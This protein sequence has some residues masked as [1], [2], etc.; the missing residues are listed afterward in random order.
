MTAAVKRIKEKVMK[1]P[2]LTL[3][4]GKGNL[5]IETDA[6]AHTWGGVLLEAIDQ[7]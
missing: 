2:A 3:P 7:K 5:I 6:S 1:L 4:M